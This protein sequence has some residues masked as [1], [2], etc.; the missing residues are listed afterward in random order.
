MRHRAIIFSLAANATQA[1]MD[2]GRSKARVRE[3]QA[4]AEQA[5][6]NYRKVIASA[7]F[8]V[9]ETYATLDVN[10]QAFFAQRDRVT[11][12][13]RARELARRGFDSGALNYL[14]VLDADRNWYQA[15][16]DQVTAYKDQLTGQVAAFKALGGGYAP[17]SVQANANY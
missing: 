9:R 8:D 2:G 7:V 14:D 11:A 6:V 15:Q 12:L 17:L 5:L 3:E 16:L 4:R 13:V 1:I 10:Q